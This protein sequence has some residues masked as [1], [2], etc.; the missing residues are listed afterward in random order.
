MRPPKKLAGFVFLGAL[1]LFGNVCGFSKT[2]AET[3]P[4]P[5]TGDALV[6]ASI[7][8]PTN[9]IPFF[10]ADSASA[11]ISRLIF[12]GLVKY[13]KDL[14]L[15]GDLASN[16]EVKE[17]GLVIIFHLRKNVLWQD[18]APFTAGDVEFTFW[19]LMDPSTPTPY[20][21]DFEKVKSLKVLDP[22]TVEVT[23]KEPFSPGL[24]S[25]SMGMLPRHLLAKEN[26]MKTA[27]S[28]HPVGTGPYIL[29]KWKT[30]EVLELVSN[31][32][33][34]ESRPFIDRY[35]YRIIPDQATAFLE[36]QT[37][38]LD[39]AELTPLQ[40]KKETDTAFFRKR[41]QKF[42]FPNVG[43]TYIGYNLENPI[44]KDK[45]VRKAI[46]LAI[47][48]N[49]IMD[50]TLLGLGKVSTG[51]F[52]PGAWAYNP[53][54][55]ESVFDPETAK[56]LLAE[57]GW[58]DTNGDGW[59]DK[60]ANRFS[61]T[62]LTNQG[63]DQR[64]MACEVIQKRLAEVGIEM[65]IQ[66]VEW[67]TFLKEFI[68][69]KRFEA[70]LLAWQ[71]SYDP[72]IFDIFHSSKSRPGEFNFVSYKNEEVDR[73]LEEGR[74]IFPEE[75]RAKIYHRIHEILS[76]DEPYTFLYV[77]ESLPIV[78]KRFHGVEVAPAG[79]GYNFIRWFVPE[80]EQRYKFK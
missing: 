4:R 25:W 2:P 37:Q 75:E 29:K 60:N 64:K 26:L 32:N 52:L 6:T 61:F 58:K 9:L 78:H 1:C 15:V 45:K 36:L 19:K 22:Y 34:F 24:A 31:K 70:V 53:E 73:L 13:D 72:D 68:D 50:V 10:A 28:R 40:Y 17:H 11:D 23:Y 76:D 20:G 3:A 63:N 7:G 35:F 47:N 54:V 49:E 66:M 30:G 39:M 67:G 14:K 33:Y 18:G 42:R 55:K 41:Y 44:F 77:A 80:D 38:N 8:E 71:L 65:K 46:G 21:G 16:W 48:K 59:L 12:N 74:R 57:A 69:K 56:R 62:I 5:A 43:Y 79:I 51:P 27:F